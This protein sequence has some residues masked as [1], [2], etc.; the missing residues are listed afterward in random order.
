MSTRIVRRV[1]LSCALSTA[2]LAHAQSSAPASP[3]IEQLRSQ[4]RI[5]LAHRESS[6]PFSYLGPDRQPMGY[7]LDIC[8]RLV[9]A[10]QARLGL[11]ALAIEYRLVTAANRIEAIEKG[12]AHLEC[13]STT[14]NAERRQ[15][16]AF[17]IPH[18][19]TGARMLVRADSPIDRF[20]HPALKRVAS[21]RGST[22]LAAMRRVKGERFL[23][24]E[25]VE[26]D[27]HEKGVQM[28]ERGEV[29]AFVMDD[30]LLYG[31]AA[32]RADPKALRVTGRFITT[33]PLAI[34]L[35]RNDAAFKKIVDDEMRRLILEREIH[36]IYAR[37]FEQPIPPRNQPL[38]LPISYLLRD[39]WKYP[40]DQ[41]P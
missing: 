30:V 8:K 36:P 7:A 27:D 6:V 21:T 31:L 16:V 20:D 19:I 34:M 4:G 5:V 15:R 26:A 24:V 9:Q 22:P 2:A 41:V 18:F 17:T 39:F 38:N 33:E 40:S 29:D 35:T 11:P 37:W 1:L 3:V 12:E 23:P 10:I 25:I 13:G 32:Q 14:N 28:V